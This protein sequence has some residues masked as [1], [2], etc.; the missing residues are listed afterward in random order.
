MQLLPPDIHE[1]SNS[2]SVSQFLNVHDSDTN[3]NHD[4]VMQSNQLAS[5]QVLSLPGVSNSK[6]SAYN[7]GVPGSIPCLEEY[8]TQDAYQTRD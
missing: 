6:A 5:D 1:E 3:V 7:V 4:L 2:I 8:E